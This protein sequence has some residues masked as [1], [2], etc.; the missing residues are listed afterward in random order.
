MPYCH[1][2]HLVLASFRAIEQ[3]RSLIRATNTGLSAFVDPVGRLV[4]CSGLWTKEALVDRIPLL[5]GRTV[6]AV[7]GDWLAWICAII[8]IA[9]MSRAVRRVRMDQIK[10]PKVA[11]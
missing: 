11:P 3:R 6:Y 8:S 5:R 4:K 1:G 10:R 9:G 2:L 7:T